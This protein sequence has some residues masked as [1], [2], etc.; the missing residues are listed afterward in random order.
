MSFQY[1][2]SI[3]HLNAHFLGT[4]SLDRRKTPTRSGPQTEH[5]RGTGPRSGLG[6]VVLGATFGEPHPPSHP[7]SVAGTPRRPPVPPSLSLSQTSS[8]RSL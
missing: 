5:L 7:L 2:L 6:G 4:L 1:T 3:T 8:E